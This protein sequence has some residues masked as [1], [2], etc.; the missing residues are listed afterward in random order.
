MPESEDARKVRQIRD[1]AGIKKVMVDNPDGTKTEGLEFDHTILPDEMASLTG[2]A[3]DEFDLSLRRRRELDLDPTQWGMA[4]VRNPQSPLWRDGTDRTQQVKDMYPGAEVVLTENGDVMRQDDT[5]LM[6]V[7]I[8]HM[9]KREQLTRNAMLAEMA[10][11]PVLMGHEY[12]DAEIAKLQEQTYEARLEMGKHYLSDDE[13]VVREAHREVTDKGRL[14]HLLE[15]KRAA[16]T[17]QRT[18]RPPSATSGMDLDRA[19]RYHI[20]QIAIQQNCSLAKATK[21]HEEHLGNLAQQ[22]RNQG[23]DDGGMRNWGKTVERMRQRDGGNTYLFNVSFQQDGP[24]VRHARERAARER[25]G[26]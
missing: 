19:F 21:L 12:P 11:N 20:Q 2:G 26:Q 22:Q 5:I 24:N 13:I 17:Y 7:P 18:F 25:A 6:K 14:A 4:W 8:E 9:R 15:R 3:T 23:E 10:A 16:R 1:N